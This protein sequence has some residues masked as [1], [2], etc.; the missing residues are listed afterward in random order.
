M[1]ASHSDLICPAN[2]LLKLVSQFFDCALLIGH[3][4]FHKP[5]FA[6]QRFLFS[7]LLNQFIKSKQVN[8]LKKKLINRV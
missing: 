2:C 6:F 7:Q 8:F 4:L 3:L 1:F 5:N